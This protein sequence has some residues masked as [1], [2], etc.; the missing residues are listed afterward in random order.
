[1]A[2]APLCPSAT[3][4]M[5]SHNPPTGLLNTTKRSCERKDGHAG[6]K[7]HQVDAIELAWNR[8]VQTQTQRENRMYDVASWVTSFLV[9]AIWPMA[10]WVL[11]MPVHVSDARFTSGLPMVLARTAVYTDSRRCYGLL[12]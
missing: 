7:H 12:K 2:H 11:G 10:N 9:D 8:R 6:P 5:A 1:M 3:A 4:S